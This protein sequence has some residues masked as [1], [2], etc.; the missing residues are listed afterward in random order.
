MLV[1]FY[2]ILKLEMGFICGKDNHSTNYLYIYN[3]LSRLDH[4]VANGWM[5]LIFHLTFVLV[6]PLPLCVGVFVPC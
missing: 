2:V 1:K 4:F 5:F 6:F 3:D